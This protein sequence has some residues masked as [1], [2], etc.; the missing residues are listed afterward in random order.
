MYVCVHVYKYIHLFIW[1]PIYDILFYDMLL[2]TSYLYDILF[3][4]LFI[5]HLIYTIY[6][7]YDILHDNIYIYTL[8]HVY[9]LLVWH[10][11]V[12]CLYVSYTYIYEYISKA[13][14]VVIPEWAGWW[15]AWTLFHAWLWWSG[16]C[17]LRSEW[18]D[19]RPRNT[20][21]GLICRYM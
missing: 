3:D 1:H 10:L 8:I 15:Y 19:Y 18:A 11:D 4:I 2:M 5:W 12:C 17:W 7:S 14:T 9:V 6:Y 16:W 13:F 20:G 21:R